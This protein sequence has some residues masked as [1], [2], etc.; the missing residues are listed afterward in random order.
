MRIFHCACGATIF[1]ENTVCLKC[2]RELGYLTDRQTMS[3]LEPASPGDAWKALAPEAQGRTYRKCRNYAEHDVCNW[4]VPAEEPSPFCVACRLNRTIPDL[5]PPQNRT[6]WAEIESAKRRLVYS[7]LALGLPVKSKLEDEAQGLA[8]DFLADP[9]PSD[10]SPAPSERIMTGHENGIITFNIAEA[11]EI[12]REQIRRQMNERYRTLLGHFRHES[13]HYY[14]ERLVRGSPFEPA[15]RELF[16]DE[17]Q[18]YAEALQRHY[19]GGGPPDWQVRFISVYASSH[20]WEDWAETWAH[21]L[22]MT[23][24]LE[25]SRAFGISADDS[26]EEIIEGQLFGMRD[27]RRTGEARLGSFAEL[28]R[29]C[30]W[31]TLALNSLSRGMGMRDAYPFVLSEEVARKLKFVHDV[32]AASRPHEQQAKAPTASR[33]GPVPPTGPRRPATL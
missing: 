25:T 12:E 18:D 15:F 2:K 20:P 1:F 32:V 26:A 3:S 6:Y 10:G 23:D 31:E 30:V 5:D 11:D 27:F 24:T 13:G 28:L 9:A 33:A 7:L 22:H 8:F 21:Y 14:W 17:R 16:G 29:E 19:E 4:M